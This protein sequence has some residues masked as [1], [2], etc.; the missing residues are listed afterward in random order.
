MTKLIREKKKAFPDNRGG[1]PS[2]AHGA[3]VISISIFQ[4]DAILESVTFSV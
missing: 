3:K 1:L 4:S 2:F